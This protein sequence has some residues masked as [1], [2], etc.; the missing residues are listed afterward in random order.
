M[1]ILTGLVK[2]QVLFAEHLKK[3]MDAILSAT[4]TPTDGSASYHNET[5]KF[6]ALTF[7]NLYRL[8]H[9]DNPLHGQTSARDSAIRLVTKWLE[10][11]DGSVESFAASLSEWPSFIL[12][13]IVD[14][15]GGE[16]DDTFREKAYALVK[17]WAEHEALVKPFGR[18]SPNHESWRCGSLY[19]CGAVFDEPTWKE[20]ALF[21]LKQLSELQTEEGF[22]EEGVHHGPSMKYNCL[23][24][25]P[26]AWVYR[27]SGEDWVGD[28]ARRLARFMA[29]WV[30][31]DGTTVGAFDG[32][33]SMS[34]AYWAPVCPGLE[35][36]PEG[37]TLNQRGVD[38][39][40]ERDCLSEERALGPSNWY[41]HFGV[42]FVADALRYYSAMV[43]QAP[44]GKPLAIDNVSATLENHST[45]FDGL[46]KR[47][48][49]WV[50]A[51]SSQNSDVPKDN[52][53][54]FRLERQSRI[55]LWHEKAGEIIGGGHNITKQPV[56]YA[57]VCLDPGY[58]STLE[59]GEVT[60]PGQKM[61]KVLYMPR[62]AISSV[63]DDMAE[64]VQHFAHGSITFS[65]KPNG[66]DAFAIGARWKTAGARRLCLQIPLILWRKGSVKL[67]GESVDGCQPSLSRPIRQIE[68]HDSI[69]ESTVTLKVTDVG[70]T[71]VRLGL[72][73]L[74]TYG[75]L[76]EKENFDSPYHILLVTTQFDSADPG[77]EM[78]W[79]VKIC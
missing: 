45:T 62:K 19:R 20:Q 41:A 34:P 77:G 49:P 8:D 7:A 74:R 57:N 12:A 66:D 52:A 44:E 39:W 60:P 36:I 65:L 9:K 75:K 4:G 21:F 17:A 14:R 1:D 50:L 46:M 54:V 31:P 64:L 70:E 55:E 79:E 24:L 23:M 47:S 30:F 18:T 42:F 63:K 10:Q 78:A 29:T 69:K 26:L 67:D 59:F 2:H 33:Q 56:P 51:L 76:F 28:M 48:G 6:G 38:L 22:W 3:E 73:P 37:A 13:E 61:S 53:G 5:Y 27:M 72:E 71:R 11:A 68:V 15:F 16:I 40:A 35:L 32:R 43:P 58:E 25:S